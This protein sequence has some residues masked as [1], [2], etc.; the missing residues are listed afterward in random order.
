MKQS[1]ISDFASSSSIMNGLAQQ[2]ARLHH[3]FDV[4]AY[5]YQVACREVDGRRE[6][7]RV[8]K[9]GL[10]NVIY[11]WVGELD[12]AMERFDEDWMRLIYHAVMG[13]ECSDSNV[14][15]Q[16]REEIVSHLRNETKWL[17]SMVEERHPNAI[18][19][20]THNDLCTANILLHES[21]NNNL[22]DNSLCIIDYEYGSINYTMYDVANFFCELCGGND[23]PF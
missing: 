2:L 22:D 3:G 14:T 13:K 16:M 21:T 5:L 8:L 18:V 11:E 1:T 20:F 10:W 17:Q 6:R 23:E 12:G 9:A 7:V 4:P 19:A 15:L